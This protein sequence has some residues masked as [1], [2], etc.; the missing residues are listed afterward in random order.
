MTAAS[1]K[2]TADVSTVHWTAASAVATANMS[3]AV[4]NATAANMS[5]TTVT[6]TTCL[7]SVASIVRIV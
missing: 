2:G 5:A 7:Y 6:T 1:T 3:A 4:A